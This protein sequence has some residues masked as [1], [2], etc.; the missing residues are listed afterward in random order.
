MRGT[1]SSYGL[2]FLHQVRTR[3]GRFAPMTW[4][5]FLFLLCS[6][7]SRFGVAFLGFAFNLE[8]TPYYNAPVLRPD[9]VNG[10]VNGDTSIQMAMAS[11]LG[12]PVH[13]QNI[14]L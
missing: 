12:L 4:V 11:A 6:L 3:Q 2:L 1:L 9:W 10:T 5:L 13:E 7:L 14:G 8:D